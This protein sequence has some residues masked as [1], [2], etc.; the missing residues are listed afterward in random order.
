MRALLRSSLKLILLGAI[1]GAVVVTVLTLIGFTARYWWLGETLSQLRPQY[2]F[3]LILCLPFLVWRFRRA[4][5]LALIPLLLNVS[6]FASLYFPLQYDP[7]S[8]SRQYTA[9]HYNL[10]NTLP[11][12]AA[13]FDYLRNHPVDILSLQELTPE[14]AAR[15][16]EELPGYV[17]AYSHPMTNS[18]GSAVLVSVTSGIEVHSADIIHLP[19]YSVRPIIEA[20]LDID[21]YSVA[22]LSLHVIRPVSAWNTDFQ[23]IEFASA[24]EWSRQQ[25]EQGQTVLIMGDLNST[26]WSRNF[27][28]FQQAGQLLDSE[29]GFGLEPTWPASLPALFTI[30]IDHCLYSPGI[31]IV[32]RFTGPFL[33]SDHTPI[34]IQFVLAE[35]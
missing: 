2:A 35:K 19:D 7:V 1:V 34:H 17:I 33:G 15:L 9:L 24:A 18:H 6:T 31:M 25:Q 8:T 16:T 12:H 13:A 30:P 3:A 20:M 5:W 21:G 29:Q 22:F 32:K 27:R 11:D 4:G 14:V 28:Q 23:Q 10:D 26:S